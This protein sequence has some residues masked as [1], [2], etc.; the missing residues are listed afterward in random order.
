MAPTATTNGKYT[1]LHRGDGVATQSYFWFYSQ[2][3]IA[4]IIVIVEVVR[5][6]CFFPKNKYQAVYF[7]NKD[8]HPP[9]N[10][11]MKEVTRSRKVIVSLCYDFCPHPTLTTNQL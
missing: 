8:K 3:S 7:V 6:C 11:C 9:A 4:V 10:G 2:F 1:L 5:C